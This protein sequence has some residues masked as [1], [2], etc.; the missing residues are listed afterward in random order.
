MTH[1]SHVSAM[2]TME[3]VINTISRKLYFLRHNKYDFTKK[4]VKKQVIKTF[5]DAIN[6]NLIRH[7]FDFTDYGVR[8]HVWPFLR[9][10]NL[11]F[12]YNND[13]QSFFRFT[14]FDKTVVCKCTYDHF[15]H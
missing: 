9:F 7:E 8:C 6:M 12:L 15:K 2:E 1:F 4:I 13:A 5:Y 10:T 14:L 3:I 11:R